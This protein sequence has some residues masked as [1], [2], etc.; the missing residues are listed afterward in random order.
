MASKSLGTL[1]LDLIARIGGYEAGLGKAEREAQKRSKAIKKAFDD[2]GKGIGLALGAAFTGVGAAAIAMTKSAIDALD[3]M[4]KLAQKVGITTEE[5]SALSYAAELSGVSQEQLGSA[6]VKL[7]KNMSDAAQGTG[8]AQKGF[9]AL[10][11]SVTNADGSLKSSSQV[12]SEVAGKFK[13][14]KDGAEKTALAVNIFGKAGAEL[15]P[16]L[17]AGSTGIEQMTKEAQALGIVMDSETA[18]AAENFNDNLT[19]LSKTATALGITMATELLPTLNQ[20]T[21]AALRNA[22]DFG[23]MRGAFMGL[24]ETI[25][26]GVEPADLLEKQ[27]KK[28][29]ESIAGLKREIELLTARGVSEDFQGGVLGKLRAELALLEKQATRTG[30]ELVNQL[31]AAAGRNT[32]GRGIGFDDPRLPKVKA[33]AIGGGV[34]PVRAGSSAKGPDPDSDFKAY[35]N[36]LEQQIQKTLELTTVEKLLDDIRRG[37]LTVSPEQQKQLLALAEIIDKEKEHVEVLQLKRAASIASGDALTKANEEYQ[38]LL[39]RLLD[40]GPAAQLEKQRKE[41]QF[42]ADAFLAGAISA[43]QYADAVTGALGLVAQQI[44]ETKSIGE[45]LGMT[46][47]SAFED[48]IVEGKKFSDVVRGLEQD[49]IRI[50]TRRMVTE[51]FSDWLSGAMQGIGG[52]NGIFDGIGK[53]FAGFFADGGFIPA[54]RFGVVGEEGPELISGPANI[55]PMGGGQSVTQHFHFAAPTDSRTRA[56][57]GKEAARGLREAQRIS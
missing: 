20:L 36:S 51:P 27:N 10:G 55:T 23:I 16:L 35:L 17:N 50:I 14:F 6:M 49:I 39:N 3:E 5:L 19:R 9:E 21:E 53:L 34:K 37:S 47:A 33:P 11:I 7:S 26:G 29:A 28:T 40:A 8:E 2:A 4:G 18:K 57:V 56:Q 54:G 13:G 44:E 38:S 32:F 48:A 30:Q 52:G 41:M 15:I 22:K 25:L 24:Y 45:D 31:N 43:E 1:T 12:L 42:L 46:F